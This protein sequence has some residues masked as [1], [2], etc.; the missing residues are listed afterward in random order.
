[1]CILLWEV[2]CVH[3]SLV[4]TPCFHSLW[5]PLGYTVSS[6]NEMFR[7]RL[8][9]GPRT[10]AVG[11][12]KARQY[13]LRSCELSELISLLGASVKNPAFHS[14]LFS[15]K[16][17][18]AIF[19]MFW[20]TSVIEERFTPGACR[21]FQGLARNTGNSKL[22]YWTQM[23]ADPEGGGNEWHVSPFNDFN[24]DFQHFSLIGGDLSS[25]KS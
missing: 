14:L 4:A 13:N 8:R 20:F 9:G 6:Y 7:R 16:S 3:G 5:S 21:A 2:D 1:M 22:F 10:Y 15:F 18:R 24:N 19:R 25:S 17:R 23:I 12:P 11:M